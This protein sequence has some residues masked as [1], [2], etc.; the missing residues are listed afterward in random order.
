MTDERSIT[1]VKTAI[2]FGR[3]EATR[4][5][6]A[7]AAAAAASATSAVAAA[8][9]A[10]AAAAAAAAYAAYAAAAEEEDA[11]TV[12]EA[13]ASKKANQLRTAEICRQV[14]PMPQF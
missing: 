4:E 1:A 2:A 7:Y 6:L 3:G 5:E 14:L 12:D 10:A 9:S 13:I 11:T 8:S